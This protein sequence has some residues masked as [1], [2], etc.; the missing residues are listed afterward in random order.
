MESRVLNKYSRSRLRGCL[1]RDISVYTSGKII[2]NAENG[3]KKE[4]YIDTNNGNIFDYTAD[5]L[6]CEIQHDIEINVSKY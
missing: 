3:D 5:Y 2:V 4:F 1:I 6:I